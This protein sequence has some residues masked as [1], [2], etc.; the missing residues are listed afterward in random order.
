MSSRNA[1]LKIHFT[2]AQPP[3]CHDAVYPLSDSFPS[4][5]T[6]RYPGMLAVYFK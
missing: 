3:V 5:D 6:Q 1:V 2:L 4:A